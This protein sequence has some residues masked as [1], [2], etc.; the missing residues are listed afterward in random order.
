MHKTFLIVCLFLTSQRQRWRNLLC[1]L[2]FE[3][4]LK[5]ITDISDIELN[6]FFQ[7]TTKTSWYLVCYLICFITLRPLYWNKKTRIDQDL[8]H[9]ISA[10]QRPFEDWV[11][12]HLSVKN[13]NLFMFL[14]TWTRKF[15]LYNLPFLIHHIISLK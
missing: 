1:F 12:V 10:Q 9:Y 5:A 4:F 15:T 14:S 6:L 3:D 7:L 2:F 8:A 13:W 11:R